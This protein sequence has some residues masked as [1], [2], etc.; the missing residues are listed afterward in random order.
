MPR[1]PETTGRKDVAVGTPPSRAYSIPQFCD[2]VG[3]SEGLFYK[4]KK[5]GCGPRIMKIGVRT[6]ITIEA[7]AE[8]CRKREAE[9]KVEAAE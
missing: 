4:L 5:E 2:A 3:I 6:L 8:W 7:A 9:N 1:H